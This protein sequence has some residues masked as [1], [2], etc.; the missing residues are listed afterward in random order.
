MLAAITGSPSGSFDMSSLGHGTSNNADSYGYYDS[1][2]DADVKI[3]DAEEGDRR[4]MAMDDSLLDKLAKDRTSFTSK[5]TSVFGGDDNWMAP[6]RQ[7]RPLSIISNEKTKDGYLVEKPSIASTSFL[8]FGDDRM[9]KAQRGLLER[10]SLEDKCLVADGK[11]TS[12]SFRAVPVFTR[13]TP[14]SRSRSCTC[15]STSKSSGVDTPPLSPSDGSS[16]S[17]GSMSSIDL[18][19]S[20]VQ[21]DIS[22]W[23][24][25]RGIL[26]L[27][28]YYTLKDE[29]TTTVMESQRV[30]EDTPFSAF[31]DQTFDPPRQPDAMQ[32]LLEHSVRNYVLL[33]AELRCIRSRKDSSTFAVPSSWCLRHPFLNSAL[34]RK[35]L[36]LP[37]LYINNVALI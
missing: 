33:P 15:T 30:W 22:M 2:L 14:A 31:A 28:K 1:I 17:G 6:G 11:D 7:F 5:A 29:A 34:K 16:I 19:D 21:E 26:A 18:N 24:D 23:D 4:R 13:P 20:F 12:Y 35:H 32:A 9:I 3:Y 25:E 8:Q 37:F 10:A 36:P 27:R